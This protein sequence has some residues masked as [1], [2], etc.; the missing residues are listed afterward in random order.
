MFYLSNSLNLLNN[1]K[2]SIF[3]YVLFHL[4]SLGKFLEKISKQKVY[5]M[6][7]NYN[8]Y[9]SFYS[10]IVWYLISSVT[11]VNYTVINTLEHFLGAFFVFLGWN[12]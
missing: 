9:I 8:F 1:A 10:S 3:L 2:I 4:F 6:L 5:E 12:S 11:I 7:T